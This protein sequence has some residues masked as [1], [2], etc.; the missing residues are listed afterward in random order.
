MPEKIKEVATHLDV[1]RWA[2]GISGGVIVFL[3]GILTAMVGYS[4]KT[5]KES[6]RDGFSNLFNHIEKCK[7]DWDKSAEELYNSRNDHSVR[8]SGLEIRF[9]DLKK[10]HDENEHKRNCG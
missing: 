7:S 5:M 6:I 8:I 9:D 10:E 3:A 2:L 4:V 1:F